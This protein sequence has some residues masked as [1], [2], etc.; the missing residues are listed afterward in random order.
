MSEPHPDHSRR[1]GPALEQTYQFLLWLCPTV[2]KFPRAQKFVLGDRIQ[3]AA[4]E[5]LEALIEAT[6]TRGRAPLLGRANLGIEKLRFLI[7]LAFD[8]KCLDGR[9]YAFAA[10]ALDEIGRQVGGWIK[11]HRAAQA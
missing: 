3:T 5:V 9:R 7:R 8:L 11:A 4:L 1:T 6:Y 10:K 2:E